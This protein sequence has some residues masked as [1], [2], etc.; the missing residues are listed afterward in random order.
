MKLLVRIVFVFLLF[1][2]TRQVDNSDIIITNI[3]IIDPVDHQIIP[4]QTIFI[5]DGIIAE[6]FTSVENVEDMVADSIIDGTGKY[7]LSGFWNMH[8]HVTWKGDL[9]KSVFPVLLSYGITG[10]RDMGG[11]ANILNIFKAQIKTNPTSGPKLYGPGPLLDGSNPIHPDFSEAITD[12]NVDQI[13]DSLYNKVDFYKVYSLL[14]ENILKRISAYSQDNNIPIAGH[15]SEYIT[16]TQAAQLGYKSFEH[17][18]RIEDIRSDS[19][20]LKSF[21]TAAKKSN[22]W[23]CPTLVIYQRKVQIAEGQ[24]LSHP[25]YNKIDNNLREEW[26]RA[27]ENREGVGSNPNKLRELISIFSEQKELVKLFY[28]KDLPLLI[29]SDF[30]GMA[31]VYPGYSFHEEMHLLSQIGVNNYDVLKMATYNPA[32]YFNITD[33]YGSIA[34][35]KAADLV[36][37]DKNPVE[38]IQNTLQ[39]STV[40]RN[41]KPLN[42]I[43]TN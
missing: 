4:D 31:F 26:Q 8:T 18:N 39:I 13:L 28:Q 11:D 40:I 3:N 23:F 30:G 5:R 42:Y 12:E 35:G 6:I 25:L 2:C 19:A 9:D 38:D 37:M 41:G 22:A 36:I 14:P 16:P 24:D 33:K 21:I 20:E 15:V 10:V 17:L 27:K 7:V 43:K 1:A 34:E 29:G 32:V